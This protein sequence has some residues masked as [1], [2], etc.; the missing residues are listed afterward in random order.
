MCS[1]INLCE[2]DAL[3]AT[4]DPKSNSPLPVEDAKWFEDVGICL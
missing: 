3:F 1:F 2:G 4:L